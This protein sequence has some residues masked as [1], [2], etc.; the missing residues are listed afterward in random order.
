MLFE[1]LS[2]ALFLTLCVLA[3]IFVILAVERLWLMRKNS[4]ARSEDYPVSVIEY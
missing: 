2:F 4:G 1:P 3:V